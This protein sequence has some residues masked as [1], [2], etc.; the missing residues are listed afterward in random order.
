MKVNHHNVSTWAL[1]QPHAT[2]EHQNDSPKVNIFFAV[3]REKVYCLFFNFFD[4]NILTGNIPKHVMDLVVFPVTYG[5]NF[6]FQQDR[7]LPPG[8]SDLDIRRYLNDEFLQ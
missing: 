7:A 2:V 8:N 5:N 1:E 4:E 3:S 6:I